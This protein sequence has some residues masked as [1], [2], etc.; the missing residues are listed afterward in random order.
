[1]AKLLQGWFGFFPSCFVPL[2]LWS[3]TKVVFSLSFLLFSL[4]EISYSALLFCISVFL[5]CRK[6]W[7]FVVWLVPTDFCWS[8]DGSAVFVLAQK[9]LCR[10]QVVIAPVALG[11]VAGSHQND[12]ISLPFFFKSRL[13]FFDLLSHFCSPLDFSTMAKDKSNSV[14]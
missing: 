12:F 3:P 1:M 11:V 4:V 10:W 2:H 8:W 6:E 7:R 5:L 14:L 13:R 9:L